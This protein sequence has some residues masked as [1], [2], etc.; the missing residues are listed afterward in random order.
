MI[1]NKTLCANTTTLI[2]GLAIWDF[3]LAK[4]TIIG[5]FIWN[6]TV[7][8]DK[9]RIGFAFVN[10]WITKILCIRQMIIIVTLTA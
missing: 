1:I 4:I 3:W 2:N 5:R 6:S 7:D 9:I 10:I 8:T